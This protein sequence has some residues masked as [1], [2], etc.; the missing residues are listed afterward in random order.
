MLALFR[1]AN[2]RAE[3][4][5]SAGRELHLRSLQPLALLAANSIF[6]GDYLTE[7][8]QSAQQDW[9]MLSD[10]GLRP[11]QTMPAPAGLGD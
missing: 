10:L 1:L 3:I 4:R 9:Q 5:A 11:Q 2:P 7:R 6:L 8:G